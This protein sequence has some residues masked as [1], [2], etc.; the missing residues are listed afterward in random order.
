MRSGSDGARIL[1]ID[2][3]RDLAAKALAASRTSPANA[4]CVAEALVAADA[5][6][7]ASHGVS[8]VPFYADQAISGKVDGHA[9]PRRSWPRPGVVAVD[10]RDGFAY[11][12]IRL[13]LDAGLEW[14]RET[15]C[16]FVVV[17]NSHH[18]GAGGRHVE[19][20]AEA[21]IVALG[22]S[23]SPAGI[24]PW[25]GHAGTFG[26]NPVAFACPRRGTAPL[27]VDLSLAVAARGKVMLAAGRGDPIPQE[28]ALDAQG[29]PTTDPEAALD[30][31]TMAPIGGAKGA[32]LALVVELLTAAIASSNLGFEAGSFFTPDGPP[33][34]I[35]QSFILIDPGVA[36][37][38]NFVS[39]TETLLA[40]ILDQPG[41]RLPGARRLEARERARR[42]GIAIPGSL[43]D[44]LVRRSNLKP[45]GQPGTTP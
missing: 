31:G 36:P 37:D 16:V 40:A 24:A 12:A 45:H 15:G 26:T 7:I 25:G 14:V 33:P 11:P 44:D 22:F 30:G 3:L 42:D 28:W 21:G 18:A 29:H 39:R 35:A 19:R 9:E 43:Y 6:G 34:R 8:R 1:S 23:N 20:M 10:A 41:T 2:A 4:A 5:D 27:V 13:A 17:S 38:G 32:A